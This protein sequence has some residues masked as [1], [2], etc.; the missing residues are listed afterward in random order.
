MSAVMAAAEFYEAQSDACRSARINA[1]FAGETLIEA[2]RSGSTAPFLG[3]KNLTALDILFGNLGG[4]EE[5]AC[6]EFVQKI[7][8]SDFD[9]GCAA[10]LRFAALARDR[11]ETQ[12]YEAG[13]EP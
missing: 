3:E 4:K 9:A 5:E 11:V 12:S 6:S 2:L 1:Q 10:F 7:L 8:A 13:S